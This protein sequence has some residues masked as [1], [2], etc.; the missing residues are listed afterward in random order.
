MRIVLKLFNELRNYTIRHTADGR[1]EMP[2]DSTIRDVLTV[3]GIPE[4]EQSGLPL[5]R[6]GRPADLDTPLQDGDAIVAF[7]PMY[8]G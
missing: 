4:H 1:L 3:L 6:N 5:F 8:G 7:S 2:Q